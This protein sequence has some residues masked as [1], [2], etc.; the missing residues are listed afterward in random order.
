MAEVL[1]RDKFQIDLRY[2]FDMS[3]G[4]TETLHKSSGAEH[5]CAHRYSL[6]RCFRA[7]SKDISQS[8]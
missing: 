3:A 1:E 2:E 6:S 5:T 8:I 4:N 7:H